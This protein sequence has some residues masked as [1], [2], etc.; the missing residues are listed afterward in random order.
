MAFCTTCGANVTGAF[1]SQ[2]GTPVAAAAQGQT[3]PPATPYAQPAVPGGP[4]VAQKTSPIVWVLI[5]VLGFL[6][7]GGLGVVGVAGYIAHRARQAGVFFDRGRDGGFA[8]QARGADGKNARVEIG[9]SA[10]KLPS[11]VPA[12]PGSEA[13][14]AIRGTGDGGSEGGNFTFT[15]PDSASRV[16]AFYEDKCKELGL[17]TQ[18]ETSAGEGGTIVATDEGA[19]R[20][21]LTV[22]VGGSLS[23]RT[24]VNVTYGRK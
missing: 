17:Q 3:G 13:V 10:G 7:L 21:S 23:G 4:P 2:C 18:V 1:C 15:T 16:K 19:D 5:I 6:V 11:W 9:G 14:L 22:V 12:Y 24:T 8:F 20:R